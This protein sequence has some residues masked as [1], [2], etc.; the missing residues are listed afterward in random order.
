MY[1]DPG[2]RLVRPEMEQGRDG[3]DIPHD[4]GSQSGSVASCCVASSRSFCCSPPRYS[5]T[6]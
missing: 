1:S 5:V 4:E 2:R 3:E 6:D